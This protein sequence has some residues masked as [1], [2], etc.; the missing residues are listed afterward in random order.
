M[1]AEGGSLLKSVLSRE[2]RLSVGLDPLWFLAGITL[3]MQTHL[4]HVN[5]NLHVNAQHYQADKVRS[6][7]LPHIAEN[8]DMQPAQ[9]STPG[10]EV[11]ETIWLMDDN[12]RNIP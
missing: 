8:L 7:L 12:A 6:I 9:D 2:T 10:H 3:H 1:S 5:S 11:Y 4:I